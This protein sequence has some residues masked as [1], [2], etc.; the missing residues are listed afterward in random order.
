MKKKI[1]LFGKGIP[2]LA[3]FVLGIALVSAALVPYLSNMI[4][5]T[6]DVDSPIQIQIAEGT[7]ITPGDYS[8][9]TTVTL[10]NIVGG[11]DTQFSIWVKS[12]SEEEV[13]VNQV[14]T[15]TC[16][17]S[18]YSGLIGDSISC[19]DFAVLSADIYDAD[20]NF[21]ETVDLKS[22]CTDNGDSLTIDYG[23]WIFPAGYEDFNVVTVEFAINAVGT[24]TFTSQAIPTL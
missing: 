4:T 22:L 10:M 2:V 19:D 3:I 21:V 13:P 16:D 7:A 6:V 17:A 5:G 15:I 20:G 1:N 8:D 12:N 18:A 11:E 24:Y 9:A 14:T 23:S